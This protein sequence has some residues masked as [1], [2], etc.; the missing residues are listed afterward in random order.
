MVSP[1]LKLGAAYLW[2]IFS[3]MDHIVL[4]TIDADIRFE[5]LKSIAE[6]HAGP[7]S[8]DFHLGLEYQFKKLIAIRAGFNEFKMFTVGAGVHLPKLSIDY[9][10][11][12]FNN[13]DQL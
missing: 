12:S 5:N 2:D 3:D 10:F 6:V 13:Q 9:A 8:A 1:T 7:I 4:P 11:Q